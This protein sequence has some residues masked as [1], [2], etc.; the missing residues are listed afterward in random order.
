MSELDII[1]EFTQKESDI[2]IKNEKSQK[3]SKSQPKK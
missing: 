3:P 1:N 2:Y